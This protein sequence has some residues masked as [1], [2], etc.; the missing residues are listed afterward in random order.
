MSKDLLRV[1]HDLKIKKW[2]LEDGYDRKDSDKEKAYPF[3]IPHH[4]EF[5]NGLS[6]ELFLSKLHSKDNCRKSSSGFKIKLHLPV[7]LPDVSKKYLRLP[8]NSKIKIVIK[9]NVIHTSSSLL[10]KYEPSIRQC[11]FTQ[12][13][14]LRFFR[15][16][17]QHN[18]EMEC[19]ANFTKTYCGC[20]K[21]STPSDYSDYFL[22]YNVEL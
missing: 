18:C 2:T 13:R 17:T 21:F 14:E 10:N 6:I 19:F 11:F 12:E 20:V 7:E 9:P 16:Y 1:H 8:L 4:A 15:V 3:H 22:E 5:N